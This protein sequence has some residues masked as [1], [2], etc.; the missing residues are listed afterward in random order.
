MKAKRIAAIV[1]AALLA[2]PLTACGDEDVAG[3]T[4]SGEGENVTGDSAFVEHKMDLGGRTITIGTFWEANWHVVGEREENP[5]AVQ[6]IDDALREI[7]KDYNCTIQFVGA[8]ATSILETLNTSAA[9]GG[10]AYDILEMDIKYAVQVFRSN[11]LLDLQEYDDVLGLQTNGWDQTS[12]LFGNFGG[13]Q[14]GVGWY[15]KSCTDPVR[16]TM[17]FN[18]TLAEKYGLGDFYQMVRDKTWTFDKFLSVSRDVVNKSN[19]EVYALSVQRPIGYMGSGFILANNG[20]LVDVQDNKYVYTGTAQNTI[21]TLQYLADYYKAGL[22]RPEPADDAVSTWEPIQA[23]VGGEALFTVGDYW[24]ID[25]FMVQNMEDEYGVLP[26]PM[27]PKATEY[28]SPMGD[29]RFFTILKDR[30]ENADQN[31]RECAAV[32]TAIANRTLME[33]WVTTEISNTL[34]DD[35]S[36]EMLEMMRDSFRINY[37]PAIPEANEEIIQAMHKI[38]T[39][40]QTPMEGMDSITQ[41]VGGKINELYQ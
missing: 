39:G 7:E 1:L 4:P 10:K 21:D 36:L 14:Y 22:C 38:V 17:I 40:Q 33:D 20:T 32:L 28:V 37:A 30:E 5:K 2:V 24:L 35:E 13:K 3:K 9:A 23:F 29:A 6:E 19:R 26:L 18:K 27:G 12:N 16:T 25:Y 34:K 31:M 11:L 8:P 15:W 41:V